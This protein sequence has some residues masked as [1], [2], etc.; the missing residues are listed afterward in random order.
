MAIPSRLDRA[1][2]G[3]RTQFEK[4]FSAWACRHGLSDWE[5][6]FSTYDETV[7]EAVLRDVGGGDRVL[8]LGA[9]DLRLALRMAERAER[10]YAVEVNPVVV[11]HALDGIGLDLPR[12]LHVICANA[13][14]VAVPPDV[15]MAVLLMRHCRH[16]R[17]YV[18]RLVEAGCS[19]LVTNARWGMGVERID[20]TRTPVAFDEVREGWY[21]CRC[22]ATGYSG[23]GERPLGQVTEVASCLRCGENELVGDQR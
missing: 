19:R 5:G 8:D 2:E 6:W 13:L 17:A 9:G 22:G 11:A 20:L 4:G 14:D 7:Y 12:N 15:T 21:A 18:D 3:A 16:F 10:V 23:T 1:V